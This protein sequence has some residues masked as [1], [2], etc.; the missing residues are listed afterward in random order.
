MLSATNLHN[1]SVWQPQEV[2]VEFAESVEVHGV[3]GDVGGDLFLSFNRLFVFNT[4][5]I[6]NA[7]LHLYHEIHQTKSF[8]SGNYHTYFHRIIIFSS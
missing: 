4:S 2:A 5:L 8:C 1:G 3:D 6:P 7:L